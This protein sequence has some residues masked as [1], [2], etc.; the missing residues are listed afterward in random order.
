MSVPRSQG[1]ARSPRQNDVNGAQPAKRQRQRS[2]LSPL[3]LSPLSQQAWRL[4]MQRKM[5]G[6][7]T[8]K[9]CGKSTGLLNPTNAFPVSG[10]SRPL[11][12]TYSGTSSSSSTNNHSHRASISRSGSQMRLQMPPQQSLLALTP[13]TSRPLMS[14]VSDASSSTSLRSRDASI[15]GS[16]LRQ[17]RQRQL[18]RNVRPLRLSNIKSTMDTS[19]QLSTSSSAL[20]QRS[21]SQ[22]SRGND[23]A[24]GDDATLLKRKH[25][26]IRRNRRDAPQTTSMMNDPILKLV[27]ETVKD[28]FPNHATPTRE[29][30]LD[31]MA[32]TVSTP[33]GKFAFL[34][35][36]WSCWPRSTFIAFM[37]RNEAEFGRSKL[38][39][40]TLE[41]MLNSCAENY[42]VEAAV[43]HV[44]QVFDLRSE[45]SQPMIYGAAACCGR[46]FDK[47]KERIPHG[48]IVLEDLYSRDDVVETTGTY[49]RANG[50]GCFDVVF[51][52]WF[53]SNYPSSPGIIAE[54]AELLKVGG[55]LVLVEHASGPN[56]SVLNAVKT[57]VVDVLARKGFF[58]DVNLEFVNDV[59]PTN[60]GEKQYDL[61]ALTATRTG[62]KGT[63]PSVNLPF[64][65]VK[66][67]VSGGPDSSAG[68]AEISIK[69]HPTQK[70]LLEEG[71]SDFG[72][73][74]SFIN[75]RNKK[76]WPYIGTSYNCKNRPHQTGNGSKVLFRH[77]GQDISKIQQVGMWTVRADLPWRIAQ[78]LMDSDDKIPYGRLR[79][80]V[81]ALEGE[82]LKKVLEHGLW[83][84]GSNQVCE[85]FTQNMGGG[86]VEY[87]LNR[88]VAKA[89]LERLERQAAMPGASR[90][91][92]QARDDAK[93]AYE[94]I[95]HS[96]TKYNAAKAEF[97]RLERQAA[98][99]GASPEA[100]Q[101][102]DDAKA[103]L[104][105][106]PH[107]RTKYNAAK[108]EFERLQRQ[109]AMPEASRET[110]QARDDAK[111]ALEAIPHTWKEHNKKKAEAESWR[112]LSAL[113]ELG[114]EENV[115]LLKRADL[116][117]P[118]MSR[119][120]VGKAVGKAIGKGTS[121]SQRKRNAK[122]SAKNSAKNNAEVKGKVFIC[123]KCNVQVCSRGNVS[124]RNRKKSVVYHFSRNPECQQCYMKEALVGNWF[125]S[126]ETI[127]GI[128]K[129]NICNYFHDPNADVSA[130][131]GKL[132]SSDQ[133]K[134]FFI[135]AQDQYEKSLNGGEDVA[136][137]VVSS[138]TEFK[139]NALTKFF[140][141]RGNS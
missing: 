116:A 124:Q 137:T 94:A 31:R 88:K 23:Q 84:H 82:T 34:S 61:V 42:T 13:R 49:F 17:M 66:R 4:Q 118:T 19:S 45:G 14:T 29:N 2:P 121:D 64:K 56:A 59:R 39:A 38:N 50:G 134:Q 76:Q 8:L 138:V 65:I 3:R 125:T 12:S 48:H 25:A 62:K 69:L 32:R 129:K 93:A 27:I 6:L 131:W 18:P 21:L 9:H 57:H 37:E 123:M 98:M 141:P 52:S 135:G 68:P 81:Y 73:Y 89:E 97:E 70:S 41:S 107:S 140:A 117:E 90:E 92:L 130:N 60:V 63:V 51:G 47:L 83:L 43:K 105:A 55:K 33:Q 87:H 36:V 106:I 24:L 86:W 102:R 133:S 5:Q 46:V 78:L 109:A 1:S 28:F 119:K 114:S 11:M 20:S 108:A 15:S 22:R 126:I 44:S 72:V 35:Y 7:P 100:M 85:T 112:K 75:D 77:A 103:A 99:P 122:N 16:P 91:A 111:A 104:E 53:F 96:K 74:V 115:R 128:K 54:L 79:G 136:N 127:C 30:L 40:S 71:A 120:Y 26:Y 113:H 139:G 80:L 132:C 110:M 67:E 10:S 95:P 101:A 58:Q